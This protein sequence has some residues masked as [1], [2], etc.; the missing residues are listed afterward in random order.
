[1]YEVTI[2][3]ASKVVLLKKD[4][5][6][7]AR[8]YAGRLSLAECFELAARLNAFDALSDQRAITPEEL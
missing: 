1:M 7:V 8:F 4:G 2:E 5:L 6:P 3:G